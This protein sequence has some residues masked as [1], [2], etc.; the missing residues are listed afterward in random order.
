MFGR[1]E[2]GNSS[3]AVGGHTAPKPAGR[4]DDESL[5][6]VMCPGRSGGGGFIPPSW[7]CMAISWSRKVSSRVI[8][9]LATGIGRHNGQSKWKPWGLQH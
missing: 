2:L 5:K 7:A 8:H 6:Q 3:L 1:V 9:I 4:S